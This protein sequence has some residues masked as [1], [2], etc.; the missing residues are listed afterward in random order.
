MDK[1][2]ALLE[3][4][5]PRVKQRAVLVL[6]MILSLAV[7]LVV[8]NT[9]RLSIEARREE[10]VVIKL[11]GGTNAFVRRPFLYSGIWYGLGGGILAWLL[12]SLVLLW[13]SGPV[14]RLV[15]AYSGDFDLSGLG[16]AYT[17]L[18]LLVSALLGVVGAWLAVGRHL[19]AIEPR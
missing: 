10:I 19:A 13:L 15:S 16:F 1:I 12:I 9:I 7:L 17:A 18:L 14:D 11:V 8:G 5:D 3:N 6:G 2:R 4:L